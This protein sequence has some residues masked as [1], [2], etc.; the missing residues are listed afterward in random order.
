MK[1]LLIILY[2]LHYPIESLSNYTNNGNNDG[3]MKNMSRKLITPL[4]E[5]SY[6][7]NN[8]EFKS[9]SFVIYNVFIYI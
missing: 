8:E 2:S 6:F 7:M 4:F 5:V 1:M 9:F 3:N